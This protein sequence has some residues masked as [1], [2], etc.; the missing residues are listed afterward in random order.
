AERPPPSLRPRATSTPESSDASRRPGPQPRR[1]ARSEGGR[2][3]GRCGTPRPGRR[4]SARGSLRGAS[5]APLGGSA[6][7]NM[8]RGMC[9]EALVRAFRGVVLAAPALMLVEHYGVNGPKT[10]EL[11]DVCRRHGARYLVLKNTAARLILSGTHLSA[12]CPHLHHA[13]AFLLLPD[14][15]RPAA[16]ALF[17]YLDGEFRK[18]I[19]HEPSRHGRGFVLGPIQY[20]RPR[21]GPH[22]TVKAG[23]LD[24]RVLGPDDLR[25]AADLPPMEAL[26]ARLLGT[27]ARPLEGFLGALSAPPRTLLGVLDRRDRAWPR[28]GAASAD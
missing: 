16:G 8:A 1:R 22:L 23:W 2:C 17:R 27:L 3:A 5:S 13:S 14:P 20:E 12:L 25:A 11:R 21:P 7:P 28:D 6:R 9:N 18:R 4:A 24:G 10:F 26:R 19:D 15:P